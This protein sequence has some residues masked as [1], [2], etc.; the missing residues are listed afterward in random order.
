MTEE[1]QGDSPEAI[2]RFTKYYLG[3]YEKYLKTDDPTVV[4]TSY[5]T[6][7]TVFADVPY[8]SDPGIQE[9]LDELG[10]T[11]HKPSDFADSSLVKELEDGGFF[12]SLGGA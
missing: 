9:I 2:E 12:K 1:E 4:K 6:Y 11:S 10:D 5:D 3:M 7:A 8:P